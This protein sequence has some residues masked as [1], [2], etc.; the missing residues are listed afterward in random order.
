MDAEVVQ[1]AERKM[2]MKMKEAPKVT[3]MTMSVAMD[4]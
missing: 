2:K 3:S 1:A 4:R